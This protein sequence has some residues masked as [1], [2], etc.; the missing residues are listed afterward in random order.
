MQR[1]ICLIMGYALGLIQT[2][3]LVG[4]AKGIDIR[5]YGSKNAGTQ[6]AATAPSTPQSRLSRK[7]ALCLTPKAMP[8][9]KKATNKK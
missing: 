9:R 5:D 3:Y 7:R 8:F 1:I 4:R 6:S 2:G